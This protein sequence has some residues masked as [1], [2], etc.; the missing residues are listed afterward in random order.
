M[1]PDHMHWEYVPQRA[2]SVRHGRGRK[3]KTPCLSSSI[4]ARLSVFLQQDLPGTALCCL[5]KPLLC[6]IQSATCRQQCQVYNDFSPLP[7]QACFAASL[8]LLL[9]FHFSPSL[10]LLIYFSLPPNSSFLPFWE[11][12]APHDSSITL[13][14]L[15][16]DFISLHWLASIFS[17]RM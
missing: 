17:F 13:L 8:F 4:C 11:T 14:T 3:A 10:R 15:L 1:Q 2:V 6:W 12:W 5:N 16:S 7:L 9:P